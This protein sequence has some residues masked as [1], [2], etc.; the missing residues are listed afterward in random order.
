VLA[1]TV[2]FDL[3][4]TLMPDISAEVE[5]M[6][7]VCRLANELVGVDADG[8]YASVHK[9][10]R[11]LWA[12]KPIYEYSRAIGSSGFEALWAEYAGDCPRFEEF[13]AI[14]PG[15]RRAVWKNALAENGITDFD[16]IPRLIDTYIEERV[17]RCVLFDGAEA[18]LDEFSRDY[19]MAMVTNGMP[20][21][22]DI[23]L[24][25]T[26][27][28]KYFGA[29]VISGEIG[30]GKPDA[31]IFEAALEKVNGSAE[32]AVM[33]G[34][35]LERDVAGAHNAGIKAIWYNPDTDNP[36]GIVPEVEIKRLGELREAMERIKTAS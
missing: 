29:V 12:S 13:R 1:E 20:C 34:N 27:I 26:G 21:L 28:G 5:S 4:D 23:K 17:R 8:L 33:I 2:I 11:Q 7:V 31:R 24:K 10:V 25:K 6:W 3:D 19:K 35:S 36:G 18:I 30:I 16:L 14:V 22:Q 9:H 32:R 15:F